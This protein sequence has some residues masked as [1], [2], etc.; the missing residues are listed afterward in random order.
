M[1]QNVNGNDA[2]KGENY[3]EVRIR[4]VS[5]LGQEARELTEV[6]ANIL[7]LK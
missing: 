2:I 6:Y 3:Y 1:E 4:N 7:R 5:Q